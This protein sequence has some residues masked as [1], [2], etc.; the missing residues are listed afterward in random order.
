MMNAT[1]PPTQVILP[2][3]QGLRYQP[4]QPNPDPILCHEKDAL[5]HK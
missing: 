2:Q 5:C 4:T 3:A 1:D